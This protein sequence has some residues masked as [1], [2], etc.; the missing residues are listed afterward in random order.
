MYAARALHVRRLLG[1]V[2]ARDRD[3]RGRRAGQH[4]R[5]SGSSGPDP[6]PQAPDCYAILISQIGD[7]AVITVWYRGWPPSA[8][9]VLSAGGGAGGER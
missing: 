1:A 8:L 4:G 5:K 6:I 9:I 7:S 2:Y 3:L